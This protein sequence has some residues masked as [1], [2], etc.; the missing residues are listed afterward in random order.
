MRVKIGFLVL[1]LC[2]I[3]GLFAS[4]PTLV[5]IGMRDNVNHDGEIMPGETVQVSGTVDSLSSGYR[6]YTTM[7]D[8]TSATEGKIYIYWFSSA[9]DG[10]YDSFLD[11]SEATVTFPSVES[12]SFSFT[13]TLPTTVPAGTAYMDIYLGIVERKNPPAPLTKHYGD[14]AA[15]ATELDNA[16][17]DYNTYM[18][19]TVDSTTEPFTSEQFIE[20]VDASRHNADIPV[21]FELPETPQNQTVQI[22]LDNDT[23]HTTS[24][25]TWD[26][27]L[28]LTSEDTY[29]SLTLNGANLS[30]TS[31]VES[32]S[33]PTGGNISNNLVNGV[34]YNMRIRYMDSYGN[35]AAVS[36]I[37]SFVYDTSAPTP[38]VASTTDEADDAFTVTYTLNEGA[39]NNEVY[40]WIRPDATPTTLIK[41][42][43]TNAQNSAGASG[44]TAV[45]HGAGLTT[46]DF[47]VVSGS[48]ALTD[49]TL[50]RVSISETDQAGNEASETS[51]YVTFTYLNDTTTQAA[52]SVLISQRTGQDTTQLSVGYTLPENG[53]ENGVYLLIDNNGT[54]GTNGSESVSGG[55]IITAIQLSD[56]TDAGTYSGI[57]LT[58]PLTVGGNILAIEG[59]TALTNGTTYYFGIRYRDANNSPAVTAWSSSTIVWDGQTATTGSITTPTADS[60]KGAIWTLSYSLPEAA[61]DV[62]GSVQILVDNDVTHTDWYTTLTLI[63]SF[64]ASGAHSLSSVN[65]SSISSNSMVSEASPYDA[66]ASTTTATPYW[67][68]VRYRDNY[69]NTSY[70]SSWV[71]VYYDQATQQVTLAAPTNGTTLTNPF[72]ITYTLPETA[73]AGNDGLSLTFHRESVSETDHVFAITDHSAGTDKQITGINPTLIGSTTGLSLVSGSTSLTDGGSYTMTISTKDLTGNTATTASVTGLYYSASSTFVTASQTALAVAPLAGPSHADQPVL[74]FT[75]TCNTGKSGALTTVVLGKTGSA[76]ASDFGIGG[77]N[78]VKLWH[79]ADN[80]GVLDT[81]EN[82]AS[83]A[84]NNTTITFSSLDVDISDVLPGYFIVTLDES[85]TA[86]L[87]KTIQ[88]TLSSVTVVPSSGTITY[89]GLPISGNYHNLDGC[90]VVNGGSYGAASLRLNQNNQPMFRIAMNTNQGTTSIS[91]VSVSID[92]NTA[93]VPANGMKLWESTDNEFSPTRAATLI[94][95]TDCGSTVT[96]SGLTSSLTSTTKYYYLTVDVG[97]ASAI[98]T[99]SITQNSIDTGYALNTSPTGQTTFTQSGVPVTLPVTLSSFTA[100]NTLRTVTLSWTTQTETENAGFNLYRG[101]LNTDYTLGNCTRLNPELIPGAVNSTEPVNYQYADDYRV[102][103]DVTYYYWIEMIDL[104]NHTMV[105]SPLAFTPQKTS[106]EQAP[107]YIVYGLHSNYPNPFNPQTTIEFALKQGG[108]ATLEIY[109]S[110]GQHIRTLFQGYVSAD[111]LNKAVWN[112][113]DDNGKS[114]A[115]GVYFYRLR[116]GKFQEQKQMIMLR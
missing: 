80:D 69:G 97:A 92:G 45:M 99:P 26:K 54:H 77:T 1:L 12:T 116:C 74:R 66:L 61:P 28:T 31:G 49:N 40:F 63:G 75:L 78:P 79:D 115:S 50:Y 95:T 90:V 57:N 104:Q 108:M 7:D 27:I 46:G 48:A 109:N 106:G 52:T 89:S 76:D 91:Q 114:V 13:F 111:R 98:L 84:Y 32:T 59:T 33:T 55:N 73:L 4:R 53:I 22:W 8:G 17:V 70:T 71:R 11:A 107:D 10:T 81:G 23:T 36:E 112:G 29:Q 51:S 18:S 60:Y 19:V 96:F 6:L 25:S 94:G 56:N 82:V 16:P 64:Y 65:W 42:R 20:P 43:Y 44:L 87:A 2:L 83:V 9:P 72:S 38:S 85:A 15:C 41:V 86:R 47:A 21:E 102:E 3:G 39:Q 68:A 113:A 5:S 100:S 110:R 67:F 88:L 105:S 93:A 34:T 30:G 62:S 103:Y 58:V 35:S 101:L 37:H 14:M 24:S